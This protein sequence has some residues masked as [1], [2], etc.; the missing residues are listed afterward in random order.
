MFKEKKRSLFF[1]LPI[2]L[3]KYTI[4]EEKI[5]ITSGFL[6]ITDDDA[7]LYKVQDVRLTKSFFERLF[8]LGTITCYTGDKTHPQLQLMR[9]RHAK[10]I[11]L[12]IM[13]KSEEARR[14]R[15]QANREREMGQDTL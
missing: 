5:N 15:R 2:S 10:E 6:T 12:Y 11:K 14:K 3:T 1:G 8:G 13:E 7:M 4:E 9:I